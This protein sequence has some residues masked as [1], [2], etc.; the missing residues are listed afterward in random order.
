MLD[1]G[2]F[3]TPVSG[4][5]AKRSRTKDSECPRSERKTAKREDV[6]YDPDLD[7]SRSDLS[8]RPLVLFLPC[9]F[10]VLLSTVF[11]GFCCGFQRHQGDYLGTASDQGKDRERWAEED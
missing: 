4:G 2:G 7:L 5:S 8:S 6:D 11:L 1:L 9:F 10:S 3:P